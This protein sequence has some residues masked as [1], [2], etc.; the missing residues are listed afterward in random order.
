MLVQQLTLA[1]CALASLNPKHWVDEGC[2]ISL[3][4]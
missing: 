4:L 1:T 2:H 3:T